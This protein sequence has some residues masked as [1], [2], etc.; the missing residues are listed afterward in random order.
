M[1]FQEPCRPVFGGALGPHVV[2]HNLHLGK[3]DRLMSLLV[4]SLGDSHGTLEEFSG[5][6]PLHASRYMLQVLTWGEVAR[7][8]GVLSHCPLRDC[9]RLAGG[10]QGRMCSSLGWGLEKLFPGRRNTSVCSC[11]LAGG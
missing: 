7:K 4:P 3:D 5:A 1:S 6:P 10:S 2:L 9:L 8:P 11:G